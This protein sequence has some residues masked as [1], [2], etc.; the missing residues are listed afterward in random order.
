MPSPWD[1]SYPCRLFQNTE[2]FVSIYRCRGKKTKKPKEW[3]RNIRKKNMDVYNL[4]CFPL[5]F[6]S[7]ICFCWWFFC[8][9][10]NIPQAWIT[11]SLCLG[12]L[13]IWDFRDMSQGYVG[14][15][16]E[17]WICFLG[18]SFRGLY[19]G[20]HRSA[21]RGPGGIWPRPNGQLTKILGA[22][23]RCGPVLFA[24]PD[25]AS[26]ARNRLACRARACEAIVQEPLPQWQ[27]KRRKRRRNLHSHAFFFLHHWQFSSMGKLLRAARGVHGP[28]LI[29]ALT[30]SVKE[31][32]P[33]QSKEKP[34]RPGMATT[35]N[36]PL[37]SK[38]LG[39]QKHTSWS[40]REWLKT[41]NWADETWWKVMSLTKAS[42][43]ETNGW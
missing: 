13:S 23:E 11:N 18:D 42:L 29:G 25:V 41:T 20:S 1:L 8:G 15:L 6:P 17:P 30:F 22:A 12:I 36:Y 34:E 31:I 19:H 37:S 39:P 43:R 28:T 5:N 16:L 9:F 32:A 14:V 24:S 40:S 33:K 7:W 21:D 3:V 26:A 35:R 27:S 38:S 4:G 10:A 2:T